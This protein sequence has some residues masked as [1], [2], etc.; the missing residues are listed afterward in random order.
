LGKVWPARKA[1]KITV[2]YETSIY[3]MWD[4]L[5]LTTLKAPTA[6]YRDCFSFLLFEKVAMF[7]SRSKYNLSAVTCIVYCT[8]KVA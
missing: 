2:I 1:D 4:P 5:R 3:K 6:C 8:I 7:A